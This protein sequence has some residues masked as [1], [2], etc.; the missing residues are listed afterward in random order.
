[1]IIFLVFCEMC[2]VLVAVTFAQEHELR[3]IYIRSSARVYEVYY[4]KKRRHDK[5]YLCTVRCGVAIRDE[6]V[7]QIPLTESADSKPVK[8]LIERK[9]ADNGNG[10]TSEDDWVEV[11]ASDDSLLNNEKQVTN[12]F[13][14]VK[15]HLLMLMW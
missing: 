3:Q 13:A 10:R 12:I 5:E 15:S 11:K 8:D 4:T 14:Q 7:L 6:E 2:V 9:V 1:M